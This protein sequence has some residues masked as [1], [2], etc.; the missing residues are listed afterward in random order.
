MVKKKDGND[1]DSSSFDP[2]W[3]NKLPDG[4]M[5]G[6]EAM[7]TDDLKKK[8]LEC[9]NTI[10]STEKDMDTDARL[11]AAKQDAKLLASAY[12]EVLTEQKAMIKAVVFI[13]NSRGAV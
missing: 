12:K 7:T 10:V 2:K 8:L 4:W 9:E 1:V 6:A 3:K 11:E 13:L 5:D